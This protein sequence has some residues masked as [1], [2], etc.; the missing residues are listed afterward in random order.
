MNRGANILIST[1][2]GNSARSPG[3][4]THM[5]TTAITIEK[6]DILPAQIHIRRP[7]AIDVAMIATINA[8]SPIIV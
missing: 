7:V 1:S 3:I 5:T 8:G 4:D 6:M 2:S